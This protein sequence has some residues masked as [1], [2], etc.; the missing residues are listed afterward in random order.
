MV[1]PQKVASWDV[2]LVDACNVFNKINF[3]AMLWQVRLTWPTSTHSTF[4]TYRWLK[5]L[6]LRGRNIA[7]LI[8][9]GF[10]LCEPLAVV[11]YGPGGSLPNKIT[12]AQYDGRRASEEAEFP[13]GVLRQWIRSSTQ[14]WLDK[15][16]VF[17]AHPGGTY[18]RSP[19]WTGQELLDN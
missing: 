5:V 14:L 19:P 6:V 15:G 1:R 17:V 10:N 2:L 18:H 3:T 9:E 8:R 7:V 12:E 13:L 16:L 11:L 4:N